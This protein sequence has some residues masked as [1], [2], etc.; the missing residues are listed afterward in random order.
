MAVNVLGAGEIIDGSL[1]DVG[2]ERTFF[3]LGVGKEW[4]AYT[5]GVIVSVWRFGF[6]LV[7]GFNRSFGASGGLGDG[8]WL[9]C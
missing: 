5:N 2:A 7:L 8:V 1:W 9:L 6:S 3:D 4:G